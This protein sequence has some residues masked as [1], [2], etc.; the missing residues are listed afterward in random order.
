MEL[1]LVSVVLPCY[2]AENYI[3]AAVNSM[4]DQTYRE[5]EIIII[6]DCSTDGSS[7]ILRSLAAGDSRIKL[8]R[9]EINLK[10]VATLNKGISLATGKYILRMDADDISFPDRVEKQVRFMEKNPDI[11]ISGTAILQFEE[12]EKDIIMTLPSDDAVLKAKIFTSTIFFHPTVII[13][14]DILKTNNLEYNSSFHQAEDWGLWMEMVNKTRVGNIQEP[15]LK[16]R[17]VPG[18]ETRIA[19]ADNVKRSSVFCMLLKRKFE[20]DHLSL[21]DDEV[22]LYTYFVSRQFI[23]L[24]PNNSI[25][26]VVC[27]FD[28]ILNQ[29][30]DL[31]FNPVTVRYMKLY[32]SF[33]LMVT[34]IHGRKKTLFTDIAAILKHKYLLTV[35]QAFL[36]R[37][38]LV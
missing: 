4:T 8:L 35:F 23:S 11:G 37:K 5:L 32:F 16:Y 38:K 22:K 9:N 31:D 26:Q 25:K 3:T 7:E 28:K 34:L 33:R 29:A 20:I 27:I 1:P 12:G 13:R 24:M 18:S 10:L 2:N 6:D 21:S 36:W 14:R 30:K 19:A 15:L 17:I